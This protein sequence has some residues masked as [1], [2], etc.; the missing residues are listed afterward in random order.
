MKLVDIFDRLYSLTCYE[1]IVLQKLRVYSLLRF[2][3]RE[4][5]NCA[6]PIYFKASKAKEKNSLRESN[7]TGNRVIVSLT[8]FPARINNLWLVVETILRQTRKPDKIILWLSKEQ[9]TT[10]DK[11]PEELLILQTRGLDIRLMGGDIRSHKK[12]Y[13]SLLEYPNDTIITVDDDVF[14]NSQIIEHLI[15]CSKMYPN[16]ICCTNSILITHENKVLLPYN[17]WRKCDETN[18]PSLNI[19]PIGVGGVLYPPKVF[20]DEITEKEAFMKFCPTA[21]DVWLRTMSLLTRTKAVQTQYKSLYLPVKNKNNKTLH[22]VNLHGPNDMQIQQVSQYC[23]KLFG[24]NPYSY[25]FINQ[26]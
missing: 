13:Y 26:K 1:N 20:N 10:S 8:S 25:E 24:E 17:K 9:F 14:Y 5:A 23:I 21:D 7:K 18:S 6:L 16:T 11:L 3:I 12:Y 15:N 4:V 22:S 2:L 19:F